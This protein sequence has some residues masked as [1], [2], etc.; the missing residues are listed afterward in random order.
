[1]KHIKKLQEANNN[2][3]HFNNNNIYTNEVM[4]A[5]EGTALDCQHSSCPASPVC[6]EQG[7]MGSRLGTFS[8]TEDTLSN[9]KN[10]NEDDDAEDNED[11]KVDAHHNPDRLKAFNIFVRL[12]VDENLDRIVP[13]N[14]QPKEKIQ[15]II[16]ACAR[17]FPEF[18]ERTR[19][20][21][22]SY[23]KSCRRNKRTRDSNG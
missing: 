8:N 13:I 7:T 4:S 2:K 15:A 14:K 11:D 1:M 23:L 12:F 5:A 9:N 20:R 10:D 22:L 21:I 19:K 6:S 3:Q 18:A 16:D 17:Q